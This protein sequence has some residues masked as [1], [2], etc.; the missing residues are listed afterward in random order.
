MLTFEK[1]SG[2]NNVQPS[3]RLGDSELTE[4]LNVDIGLSGELSRRAGFVEISDVCHKNL[5]Q[6]DG[7][8]LATANGDLVAIHPSGE[9]H[10]IY[11]SLGPDRVW[12]CSL[13]DGRTTFSNGLI[14]GVTDGKAGQ[15][16][17][18]AAPVH[19]G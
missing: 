9:H 4:A 5:F 18:V 13:P 10:T 11:P 6:A 2:I 14:N 7:Y 17:G 19:A 16:W 8:M 12:Y 3:H 15:P 1:F